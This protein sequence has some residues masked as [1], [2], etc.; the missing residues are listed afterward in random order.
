MIRRSWPEWLEWELK[1]TGHLEERM[2][3]RGFTELDI[4]RMLADATDI[5][6]GSVQGRWVAE[7]TH[8]RASWKVI[9]EPDFE[10]RILVVVTAFE[11]D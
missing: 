5:Q 11:V 1:F 2:S 3:D 7:T 9:V 4:R 8:D 6:A 10:S